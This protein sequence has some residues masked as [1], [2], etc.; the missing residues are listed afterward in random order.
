MAYSITP[1]PII[2]LLNDSNNPFPLPSAIALNFYNNTDDPTDFYYQPYHTDIDCFMDG[3]RFRNP[4]TDIRD[5]A[6]VED[7]N[8]ALPV[9][10]PY[11]RESAWDRFRSQNSI[12]PD[13][14]DRRAYIECVDTT[15]PCRYSVIQRCLCIISST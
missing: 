9:R 11:F 5:F 15:Y 10:M 2:A 13:D 1:H 3:N 6:C 4:V 12:G 14:R 8:T 7:C